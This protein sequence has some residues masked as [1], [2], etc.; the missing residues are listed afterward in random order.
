MGEDRQEKAQERRNRIMTY[1]H[2]MSISFAVSGSKH[3]D[4]HKC[5]KH[6][7]ELVIGALLNRIALLMS[8]DSEFREAFSDCWDTYEEVL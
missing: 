4:P 1:N 2:A 5:V 7:K 3:E 6:E 8:D